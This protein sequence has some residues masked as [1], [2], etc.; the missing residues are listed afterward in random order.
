M[1]EVGLQ[2]TEASS[3]ILV[4]TIG[5]VPFGAPYSTKRHRLYV[6]EQYSWAPAM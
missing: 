4:I 6:A 3:N 5:R 1:T 2:Q